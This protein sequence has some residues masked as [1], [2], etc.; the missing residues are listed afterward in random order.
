MI[1]NK[2][3]KAIL[4]DDE[5]DNNEALRIKLDM[6]CKEVEVVATFTNSVTFIP[7]LEKLTDIDILFL[8]VEMPG[9]NGFQLLDLLPDRNFEV[10]MVTAYA[11]YAMQAIKAEALDYLLKP[12][13]YDELRKAINKVIQRKERLARLS[14]QKQIPSVGSQKILLHSATEAHYIHVDDIISIQAINNYSEF[15]IKDGRKIMISKTLKDFEEQLQEYKFFFRVHKSSI[16][17]IN[18][19]ERIL[20]GDSLTVELS[21]KGRVDVSLR[22]RNSFLQLLDEGWL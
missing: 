10:I 21:S 12:V 5:V 11:E 7:E 9:L 14:L 6:V 15:H 16:I 17:N 1:N 13:G 8:D 18:H 20:K 3:L 19:I 4:L 22:K 2:Q